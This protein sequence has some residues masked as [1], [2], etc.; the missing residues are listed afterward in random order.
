MYIFSKI[1]STH[2]YVKK[3]HEGKYM[4]ASLLSLDPTSLDRVE[5]ER[6]RG[7]TGTD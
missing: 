2:F 5:N 7:G 1:E 4:I 6:E 3:N